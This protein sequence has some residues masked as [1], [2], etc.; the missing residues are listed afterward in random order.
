MSARVSAALCDLFDRLFIYRSLV[1]VDPRLRPSGRIRTGYGPISGRWPR[2]GDDDHAKAIAEIVR[3]ARALNGI[4]TEEGRILYV[5]DTHRNDA[6][7]FRAVCRATGWAGR[8]FIGCDAGGPPRAQC[9]AVPEGAIVFAHRWSLLPD[10]IRTAAKDGFGVD[11]RTV[12]LIDVDK[13]LIGARGRNAAPIDAAR[14][15]AAY[16]AAYEASGGHVGPRDRF[17]RIYDLVNVP[18]FH[19]L[20]EDDQDAVVYLATVVSS[21]CMDGAELR[22]RTDR[23]PVGGFLDLLNLVEGERKRLPLPLARLHDSV[24]HAFLIGQR[25]PFE[26]FRRAEYRETI[27]RMGCAPDTLPSEQLLQEEIVITREVWDA[28]SIWKDAGVLLLALSDKPDE[29]C[30]PETEDSGSPPIHEARTHII[31]GDA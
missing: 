21:G 28:A 11:D 6:G 15:E 19:P 9:T 12:A 29:A 10:F 18:E 26:A 2:K 22:Q 5:G 7:A 25:A 16:G 20:T 8:A 1:P 3:D 27:A 23:R 4:G 13:T 30:L 14:R 31:G 24:R 17:D